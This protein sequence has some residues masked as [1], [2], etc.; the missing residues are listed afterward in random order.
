[1]VLRGAGQPQSAEDQRALRQIMDH[2]NRLLMNAHASRHAGSRPVRR[3][4]Y[5]EVVPMA[6]GGA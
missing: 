5:L 1:V 4:R 6:S 3:K 2:C